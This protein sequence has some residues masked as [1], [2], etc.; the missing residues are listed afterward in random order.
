MDLRHT[1]EGYSGGGIDICR[2]IENTPVG[3]PNITVQPQGSL[4]MHHTPHNE[5]RTDVHLM[6]RPNQRFRSAVRKVISLQRTTRLLSR[7]RVGAEPGINPRL[8]AST[9]LFGHIQEQ[10]LIEVVDF[11]S[12]RCHTERMGNEAF[13]KFLEHKNSREPWSKVRWINIAGLSW[14]VVK[15]LALTY[16]RLAYRCLGQPS[17]RI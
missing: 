1:G 4:N 10:C 16:G 5:N 15:A 12:V 13:I 6:R 3:I 7:R 14:D 17:S 8:Q 9:G 2:S 11:S